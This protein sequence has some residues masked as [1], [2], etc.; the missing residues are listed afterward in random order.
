MKCP[1]CRRDNPDGVKFC[2]GCGLPFTSAHRGSGLGRAAAALL[3]V[4]CYVFLMLG[5]QYVVSTFYCAFALVSDASFL[6]AYELDFEAMAQRLTELLP[7][8]YHGH[9]LLAQTL[10]TWAG[11][12]T[13]STR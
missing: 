10:Y 3:K 4:V 2:T 13:P 11:T 12:G 1:R 5:V 8:A 9:Y 6:Y 7:G